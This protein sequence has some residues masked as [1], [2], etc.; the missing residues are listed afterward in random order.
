MISLVLGLPDLLRKT[1][2]SEVAGC[3]V[4]FANLN[5]VLCL[6]GIPPALCPRSRTASRSRAKLA[7]F[8]YGFQSYHPV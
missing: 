1:F 7:A 8:P 6:F 2:D 5:G 4:F 3:R